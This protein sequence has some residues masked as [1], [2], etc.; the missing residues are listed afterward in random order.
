MKLNQ[1]VQLLRTQKY[2][3]KI[4]SM[5]TY[6]SLYSFR[7]EHEYFEDSNGNAL[8]CS[9]LPSAQKLM[10]QRGLLFRQTDENEWTILYDTENA[11]LDTESDIIEFGVLMSEPAFVFYTEW[12]NFNPMVAY[13]IDLPIGKSEVNATDVITEI[14]VKR[15]FGI[16][17]CTIMI[18]LTEE[19]WQEAKKD[20]PLKNTLIFKTPERFWEYVF[21]CQN[22]NR[23]ISSECLKLETDKEILTFESFERT[24][25]FGRNA[26][27]T[28]SEK[29]VPMRER[30][31]I[32]LNLIVTHDKEQKQY[33]LRNIEHPIPGQFKSKADKLRQVCYF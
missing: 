25:E 16:P 24:N 12:Q 31:D 19:L 22:T 20:V 28:V 29:A 5:S 27:R 30:Y 9:V 6:R 18:H 26:F 7:I 32:K 3:H 21:I 23:E 10:A 11:G 2:K 33:L 1:A 13:Q 8:M 14:G 15:S 4:D 17:F